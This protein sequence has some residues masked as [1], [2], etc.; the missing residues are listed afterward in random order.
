MSKNFDFHFLHLGSILKSE[1][2]GV[3]CSPLKQED[4]T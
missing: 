4:K 2:Y 1:Y 3:L